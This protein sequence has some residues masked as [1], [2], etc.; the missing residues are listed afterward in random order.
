MH[1]LNPHLG[2]VPRLYLVSVGEGNPIYLQLKVATN[3]AIT[4][5]RRFTVGTV[6]QMVL[7]R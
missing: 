6:N 1:P 5:F 3:D 2:F 7:L 4:T